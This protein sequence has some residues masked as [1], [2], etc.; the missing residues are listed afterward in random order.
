MATLAR[1]LQQSVESLVVDKTRLT[2]TFDFTLD[3]L[4]PNLARS[5]EPAVGVTV[6]T[7]VQE[8]L[9]LRLQSA[10]GPVDVIAI[11]SVERPSEN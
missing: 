10:R 1:R 2:G 9:G 5:Q 11:A 8:Q 7:A 3:F 4:R 6:F